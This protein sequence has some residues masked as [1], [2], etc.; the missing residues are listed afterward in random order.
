MRILQIVNPVV[1]IPPKTMG[2]AERIVHALVV[3]LLEMGHEVTLLGEDTSTP[4]DGV[5]FHGIGTY[6]HQKDT[7]RAVWEHLARYGH[8]YDAIHNHGRLVY[9]LPRIWGGAPKV[10]TIHFGDLQV[11]QVRKFLALR[12]RN[13]VFAPCGA[14]IAEKYRTLGGDWQPV[15]NGL[16]LHQYRPSFEVDP[17]APLVSIGRMDPRKGAPQAIEIAKRTGRKLLIAGVVGDQPHE[18]AWFEQN[19]LPHCDG[20][21]I[22]FIGPVDD[23]GKQSLLGGAAAL[24][25]PI[26]GS[27]AFTV[28][29]VEALA[30]GCP[31]LGFNKYCI[32]ELVRHGYNG[33]LSGDLDEMA[34]QVRNLHEIDRRNCRSDFEARFSAPL[35]ASRYVA[36]YAGRRELGAPGPNPT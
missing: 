4:P 27:E 18:R 8:R 5:E 13:A 26:Q 28:V 29:M 22:R 19:V 35:M 10:H 12:P 20:E 15:H 21:Q 30:C 31:V 25:L 2:G 6:W 14:W 17:D 1:P 3:E 33:F 11:S 36:L 34:M 23:A 16:P 9:L 32:P 7:V 24:V